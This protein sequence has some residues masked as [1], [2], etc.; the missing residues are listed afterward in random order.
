MPKRDTESRTQPIEPTRVGLSDDALLERADRAYRL[1]RICEWAIERREAHEKEVERLILAA[2]SE[3]V[4]RFLAPDLLPSDRPYADHS[5][6]GVV[7]AAQRLQALKHVRTQA[8]DRAQRRLAFARQAWNAAASE[9]A[10]RFLKSPATAVE[11]NGARRTFRIWL[12]DQG[13]PV[14]AVQMGICV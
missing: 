1:I 9:M 13:K 11:V 2:L 14:V 3:L 6:V 4:G 7:L 12:D 8:T 10:R 5:N